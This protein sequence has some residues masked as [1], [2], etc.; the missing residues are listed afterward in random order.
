MTVSLCYL[1]L[2]MHWLRRVYFVETISAYCSST[3]VHFVDV[4]YMFLR[5]WFSAVCAGDNVPFIHCGISNRMCARTELDHGSGCLSTII[6]ESPNVYIDVRTL[7]SL[8]MST[9]SVSNSRLDSAVRLRMGNAW[10]SA[11]HLR[12]SRGAHIKEAAPP[13]CFLLFIYILPTH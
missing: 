4:F 11:G 9:V 3:F 8:T 1:R 5:Y 2:S 12:A 6:G 7:H 13:F 10:R